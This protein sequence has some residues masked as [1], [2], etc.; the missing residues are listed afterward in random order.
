MNFSDPNIYASKET[1]D[2]LAR[3]DT[4]LKYTKK[5]DTYDRYV[6]YVGYEE[7]IYNGYRGYETA[8]AEGFFVTKRLPQILRI[9]ITTVRTELFILLVQD[10][11]ILNSSRK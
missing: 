7:G 3:Y 5:G 6:Y 8:A 10:C 1:A 9:N 2:I 4:T 11:P